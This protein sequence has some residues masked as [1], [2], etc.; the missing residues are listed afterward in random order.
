MLSTSTDKMP[1]I[2]LRTPRRAPTRKP[3][4]GPPLPAGQPIPRGA[5]KSRVDDRIKK[6]MSMRYAELVVSP[7][8]IP[9]IPGLPSGSGAEE[10]MS[11]GAGMDMMN[12][13]R[14][15]GGKALNDKKI[16]EDERFDP[17]SCELTSALINV[18]YIL[19]L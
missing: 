9:P 8:D 11:L 4:I 5:P 18:R 7:M 12:G 14:G 6:R 2:S 10:M 13:P 16:L 19:K 3:T 17:D 1:E 15:T